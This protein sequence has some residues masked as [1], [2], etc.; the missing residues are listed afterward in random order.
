MGADRT[1]TVGDEWRHVTTIKL[2]VLL[3]E[4]WRHAEGIQ[5]VQR[6]LNALGLQ[7]TATGRVSVS[8]EATLESFRRVFPAVAR[9]A[10]DAVPDATQA[11]TVPPDLAEYV[12]SIAV[13]PPHLRLN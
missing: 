6:I 9:E 11:L 2:E 4:P 5:R 12:D 3:K 1:P 13:V 8:A 10:P 7:T